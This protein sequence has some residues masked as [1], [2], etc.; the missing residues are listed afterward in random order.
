MSHAFRSTYRVHAFI[1][2]APARALASLSAVRL[3]PQTLP[4]KPVLHI[5]SLYQAM[6]TCIT[7]E[8]AYNRG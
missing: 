6:T 1:R 4:T 8:R 5:G 2:S 3:S 7:M